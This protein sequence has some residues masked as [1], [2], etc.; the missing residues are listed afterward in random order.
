[1]SGDNP[2]AGAELTNSDANR[3][4]LYSSMLIALM[5]LVTFGLAITALPNSP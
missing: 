1:M 4:G 3:V 2:V 5:T